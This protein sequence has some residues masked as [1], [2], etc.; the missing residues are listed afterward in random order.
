MAAILRIPTPSPFSFERTVYSH[1][2]SDLAPFRVEPSPA[3]LQA[4][5]ILSRG[6]MVRCT[7]TEDAG[8]VLVQPHNALADRKLQKELVD[9]I[10][11]CLRLDEDLS[12]FYAMAAQYPQYRWIPQKGAG[13]LLRAPTLFEDVVKMICTTNCSWALTTV[14]VENLCRHLGKNVEDR[15]FSFPTPD[16][17]ARV[18]ESFLRTKIRMGYRAPYVLAFARAV[19][20]GRLDVESLRHVPL[21]TDELA[22]RLLSIKGIGPYAAENLLRLLGHYDHLAL[23]SW[24][25]AKYYEVYHRGRVVK[26]QTIRRRYEPFGRWKGL[27]F[28]LEMTRYWF[29][30]K[31]P[32]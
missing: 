15:V 23:D 18:T 4:L 1:G 8:N 26:D 14:M 6:Q 16:R 2:W 31:F 24:V 13:R 30:E 22:G 10:R 32:F 7:L 21:S 19:D 12:N 3:R 25:R 9:Q 11:S 20:R 5:L 29:D 17:I 27:F 28:W